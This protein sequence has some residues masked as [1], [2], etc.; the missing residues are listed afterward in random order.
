MVPGLQ[1]GHPSGSSILKP[2]KISGKGTPYVR[3]PTL[4]SVQTL[5]PES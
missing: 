2:R 1:E 3:V 4:R 5:A